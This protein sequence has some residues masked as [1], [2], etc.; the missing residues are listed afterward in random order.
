MAHPDDGYLI[1][2][3]EWAGMV[4]PET[5]D[6]FYPDD[7]YAAYRNFLLRMR[8]EES[9]GIVRPDRMQR[10]EKL[11]KLREEALN[12]RLGSETEDAD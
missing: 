6:N 10:L 4:H 9:A 12:G 2:D 8:Q 5:G 11:R 1:P 7:R 3:D